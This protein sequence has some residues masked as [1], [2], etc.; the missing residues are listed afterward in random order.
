MEGQWV[1]KLEASVRLNVSERRIEQLVTSRKLVARK[2]PNPKGGRDQMQIQAGSLE[3]YMAQKHA[4]RVTGSTALVKQSL[5][6]Q[7]LHAK[8]SEA[9]I[10]PSVWLTLEQAAAYVRGLTAFDLLDMI[11]AGHLPAWL[12]RGTR[13][14]HG[15]I[16]RYRVKKTDLEALAGVRVE[17][18][19]TA[20]A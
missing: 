14:K 18:A 16:D 12:A 7:E 11:Q 8:E 13:E 3:R 9:E 10:A 19:Q 17:R 5:A 1:D 2:I 4:E 15:W 6:I 20:G